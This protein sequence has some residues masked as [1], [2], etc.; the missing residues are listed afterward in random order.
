MK[1]WT[2]FAGLAI[3]GALSARAAII[4]INFTDN[5]AVSTST[6]GSSGWWTNLDGGTAAGGNVANLIDNTNT[7]T[8]VSLTWVSFSGFQANTRGE[9]GTGTAGTAADG[10]STWTAAASTGDPNSGVTYTADGVFFPWAV[11]RSYNADNTVSPRD[12]LMSF[13]LASDTPL[14]YSFWVMS[15]YDH[16]NP[17]PPN[18]RSL[19]NIGGTYAYATGFTGGTTLTLDSPYAQSAADSL[20]DSSETSPGSV[21][22][23]V[24]RLGTTFAS[25]YNGGSGMYE[26]TFQAGAANVTTNG[27]YLNALIIEAIPEPATGG[28]VFLGAAALLIRRRIRR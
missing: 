9:G 22:Y 2:L 27:V 5:N 13:T 20:L 23:K 17:S 14:T 1:K 8:G 10:Q 28:A 7:P 4:Q 6:I 21:K 12:A 3:A 18:Y 25:V 15:S 11:I 24:G 26:I 16:Q 19:F